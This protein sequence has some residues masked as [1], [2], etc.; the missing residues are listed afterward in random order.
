MCNGKRIAFSE[1]WSIVS[2]GNLN[3]KGFV[4]S[5]RLKVFCE[6]FAQ[7]RSMHAHN[8]VRG[9]VVMLRSPKDLMSKLELMNVVQG[10]VQHPVTEV[11]E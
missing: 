7:Q 9:R 4:Y 2:A 6:T 3:N 1:R 10:F 5:V 8:V 11:K